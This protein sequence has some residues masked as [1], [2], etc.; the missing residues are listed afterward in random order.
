[1][2]KI[3]AKTLVM[4]SKYVLTNLVIVYTYVVILSPPFF[5]NLITLCLW[6]QVR[7][8]SG[9]GDYFS[10]KTELKR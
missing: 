10:S 7:V 9:E 3:V 1:M 2:A 5:I 4:F 6:G 8:R